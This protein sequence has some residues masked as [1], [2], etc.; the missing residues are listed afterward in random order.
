[1][2]CNDCNKF[3]A[4]NF[5]DPELVDAEGEVEID[6]TDGTASGEL[7]SGQVED[8]VAASQMDEM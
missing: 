5:E 2:R 6:H 7:H 3:T 4:L 1:M 8:K